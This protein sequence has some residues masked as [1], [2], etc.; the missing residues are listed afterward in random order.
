MSLAA[1]AP[2]TDDWEVSLVQHLKASDATKR[3]WVCNAKVDS[4]GFFGVS[5]DTSVLLSWLP[6]QVRVCA[7]VYPALLHDEPLDSWQS[8]Q[9]AVEVTSKYHEV[10]RV[11]LHLFTCSFDQLVGAFCCFVASVPS[12]PSIDNVERNSGVLI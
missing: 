10:V 2:P 8:A 1:I 3:H 5:C 11:C 12:R 4:G 9:P 7:N 6:P